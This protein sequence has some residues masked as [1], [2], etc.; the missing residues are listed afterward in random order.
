M[1]PTI[2]SAAAKM[3]AADADTSSMAALRRSAALDLSSV[4]GNVESARPHGSSAAA[5]FYGANANTS[6]GAALMGST[7]SDL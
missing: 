5:K 1:R 4:A 7:A 2:S 6:S 3:D